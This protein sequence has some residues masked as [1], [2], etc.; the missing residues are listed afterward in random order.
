ML[1]QYCGQCPSERSAKVM[2]AFGPI[3]AGS[4]LR[5][6][7]NLYAEVLEFVSAK[8]GQGKFVRRNLNP[9]VLEHGLTQLHAKFSGQVVVTGAG[10]TEVVIL[11]RPCSSLHWCDHLQRLECLRDTRIREPVIPVS[12]LRFHH[13]QLTLEQFLQVRAGGLWTDAGN[14]GEFSG[15]Q[16]DAAHQCGQH[17]GSG[18]LTDQ[19]CDARQVWAREVWFDRVQDHASS[20]V[21]AAQGMFRCGLKRSSWLRPHD[22]RREQIFKLELSGER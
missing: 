6:V 2:V 14:L 18:G 20:V 3:Q 1:E 5:A 21:A 4:G 11:Y 22:A 9:A 13:Q 16:C 8:F 15:G 19:G 12:A 17:R 7:W 10:V